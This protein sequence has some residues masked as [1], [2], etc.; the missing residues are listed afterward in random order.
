MTVTT[1]E[2]I[3][4]GSRL[5]RELQVRVIVSSIVSVVMPKS[6]GHFDECAPPPEPIAYLIVQRVNSG[7]IR[8]CLL[9]HTSLSSEDSTI[10]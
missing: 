2:G 3:E 6:A 8:T 10:Y 5:V 1:P 7:A 9:T 4:L